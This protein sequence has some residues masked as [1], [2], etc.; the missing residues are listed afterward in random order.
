MNTLINKNNLLYSEHLIL[1]SK[2]VICLG[3]TVYCTLAC[4][5]LKKKYYFNL[6]NLRFHVSFLFYLVYSCWLVLPQSLIILFKTIIPNVYLK[7]QV[8][9]RTYLHLFT[10][11]VSRNLIKVFAPFSPLEGTGQI[12]H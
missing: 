7:E 4:P 11:T 3:F 5:V 8:L 12:I 2:T 9:L 1:D 6:S 10:F